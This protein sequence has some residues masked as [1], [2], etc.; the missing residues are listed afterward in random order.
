MA[1]LLFLGQV[2]VISLSGVM[3]PGPVTAAAI[4]MGSRS[5]Y[6]GMLLAIGHGVVEFPLMVLIVL[7]MGR[8]LK[9]PAAQ[10][11]IGLAGGAFLLMMAVGMLKSLRSVEIQENKVA[12]STPMLAGIILS[13]GNPYF[14]FWWATVGLALATAATGMGIWAFALFAVVHW[15]C[16]FIW[17]SALSWASFKGT[18][19]FGPRSQRIVLLICAIALFFFGLF[20]IYNAAGTLIKN[21]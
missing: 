6:A 10:I 3:A 17:L 18:G 15:L 9:L 2:V 13:A 1:L 8:I 7:G 16:D 21:I 12:K 11:V 5:R 14:L 4:G 19:L 20:F